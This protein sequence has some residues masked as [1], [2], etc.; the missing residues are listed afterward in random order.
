MGVIN[1]VAKMMRD[2]EDLNFRIE[3]HTDSDGADEYNLELSGRRAEAVKTAL[4]DLGISKDRLQ[5]EGK[6]ESVPVAENTS[7][8]GKANNRR[9]EF[10]KL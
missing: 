6:G 3:G 5:T 1:R 9:V 7:P 8:E 4:I 10:V 2:H